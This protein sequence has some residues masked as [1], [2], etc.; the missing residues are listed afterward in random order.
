MA[1]LHTEPFDLSS[2]HVHLG[3]GSTASV[4][5][6]FQWTP[7][8]LDTY[9]ARLAAD[10]EEGRMVCVFERHDG[11]WRCVRTQLTTGPRSDTELNEGQS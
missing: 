4:I 5:P 10:G 8:F 1:D 3:R 9:T 7:E 2:A 6:D 11:T